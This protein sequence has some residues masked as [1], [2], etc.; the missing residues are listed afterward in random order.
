MLIAAIG[1]AIA[2][3]HGKLPTREAVRAY[4][5]AT[6]GFESPIGTIAFD[7][8]GDITE[9]TLSLYRIED[10]KT[11]L[12]SQGHDEVLS[13]SRLSLE[14]VA[15]QFVN[16][17]SLGSIYALIARSDTRWSMRIIEL[18]NF[19]HGDVATLGTFIAL[20]ILTALGVTGVLH[21]AQRWSAWSCSRSSRPC[22]CAGSPASSS[23]ASPTV[24]YATRRASHR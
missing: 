10:G 3:A 14:L 13:S 7:G 24:R 1:N 22:C 2:A 21:G 19:A 16:G 23:S 17:I 15:Q 20:G 8:N 5:A 18:I 9:N 11:L 4:V 6:R 12:V